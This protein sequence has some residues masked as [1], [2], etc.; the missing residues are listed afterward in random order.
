MSI[1]IKMNFGKR[2]LIDQQLDVYLN[3]EHR[4][5]PQGTYINAYEDWIR[6][7]ITFVDKEDVYDINEY[8]I[9][10]FTRGVNLNNESTAVKNTAL[11]AVKSFCRFYAAR[12]KRKV[13]IGQ[14]TCA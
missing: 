12:G 2:K 1:E 14:M 10:E 6:Q 9:T 3:W 13:N 7:F 5:A 8:H 4:R 11:K